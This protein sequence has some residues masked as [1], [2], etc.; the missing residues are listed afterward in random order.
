MTDSAG[1]PALLRELAEAG[2]PADASPR[3]RAEYA[4]DA[5]NYRVEPLAVAFP[6]TV[7]DV[8][9]A[10]AVCRAS[11][12]PVIAR[13]GG[14]SMAG[15]AIGPGLV[16]DFSRHMDRVR[17]V[18]EE[19]GT[20]D[21]EPGV[22]LATL[23]REVERAT[24]GR[25]TFAPDPSSKNRATVGGA[26]GNDACGNHSV[27]YGRTSDHVAEIDLVTSD[28]ARLTATE[29]GVRATDPADAFSAGRAK[30]LA[31]AL[32]RL[33]QDNLSTFRLELGRIPRQVSGYHLDN[34]L[35]EKKFNIARAVVGS[36]GTWAVVVGAY[37]ARAEAGERAARLPRLRG[38]R[39]RRP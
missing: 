37:E 1:R 13:G 14:T 24:G 23:S 17:A 26:I 6:R 39:R 32:E 25:R 22:V 19:A 11:G 3:R 20:V 15:N 4:Y 28:G 33:A 7:D 10:V 9:A 29:T 31:A 36:E 34:L 16:L 38:R 27:R 21:V 5:S 2:V 12:T 18:D 30:S 8:V 35:P